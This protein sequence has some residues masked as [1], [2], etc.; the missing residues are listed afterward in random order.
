LRG[1]AC[2]DAGKY[3]DGEAVAEAVLG[4]KLP[5]PHQEYRAGNDGD[6]VDNKGEEAQGGQHPLALEDDEEGNAL[7]ERER[8]S[9][10]PAVHAELRPAGLALLLIQLFE[11]R[12]HEREEL[13]HD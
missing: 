9:K 8:E 11:A 12:D 13:H 5:Y 10:E 6:E 1:E 2:H 4:N 7:H 3:D